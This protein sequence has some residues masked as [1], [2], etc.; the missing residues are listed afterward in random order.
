MVAQISNQANLGQGPI[1]ITNSIDSNMNK[2]MPNNLDQ[3]NNKPKDG[4]IN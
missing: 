1:K 3:M 4:N 2:D